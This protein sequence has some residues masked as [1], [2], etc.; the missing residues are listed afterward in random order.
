ASR[1]AKPGHVRC[2]VEGRVGVRTD[3]RQPPGADAA[4]QTGDLLD[5]GDFG[6]GLREKED[7]GDPP[8][9]E[10]PHRRPD[11]IT[12][13]AD[14]SEVVGMCAVGQGIVGARRTYSCDGYPGRVA[15]FR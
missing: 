11:L 15:Q 5:I 6:C 9:S 13:P 12:V 7:S 10:Y 3:D 4:E 2:P 14:E 1:P 8:A